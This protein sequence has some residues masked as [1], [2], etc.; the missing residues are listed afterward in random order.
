MGGRM[1]SWRRRRGP[2][3]ARATTASSWTTS[4]ACE[5]SAWAGLGWAG[6]VGSGVVAPVV[7]LALGGRGGGGA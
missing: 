5:R 6:R 1:L 7:A 3:T 4:R 2:T